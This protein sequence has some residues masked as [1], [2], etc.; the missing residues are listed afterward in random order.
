[1]LRCKGFVLSAESGC[2]VLLQGVRTRVMLGSGFSTPSRQGSE[3][4]F[5]GYH[6]SRSRVTAA[7]S[8]LTG[9]AW[10]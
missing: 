10:S 8:R 6:L 7:L 9:K 4:V 2:C 1:L 5:I 3:L